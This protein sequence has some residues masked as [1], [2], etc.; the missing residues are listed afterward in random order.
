MLPWRLHLLKGTF[1]CGPVCCSQ[2]PG[3]IVCLFQTL[4]SPTPPSPSPTQKDLKGKYHRASQL[5]SECKQLLYTYTP[6]VFMFWVINYKYISQ[7]SVFH[8]HFISL[9][10]FKTFLASVE[11][12][13]CCQAEWLYPFTF[14]F[15][16]R[17][18]ESERRVKLPSWLT[19]HLRSTE[20]SC[21]GLEQHEDE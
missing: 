6:A 17:W 7:Y 2:T 8:H 18:N 10:L 5:F 21:R 16:K 3:L 13:R 12:K 11:N 9:M 4:D 14:I 20:E 19:S 1:F 15:G